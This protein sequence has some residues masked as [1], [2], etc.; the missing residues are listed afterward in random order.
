MLRDLHSYIL[1]ETPRR[2]AGNRRVARRGLDRDR[3]DDHRATGQG[4]PGGPLA[5]REP[6]PQRAEH[7]LEQRDERHLG[8]RDQARAECEEDESEPDLPDAEHERLWSAQFFYRAFSL[9]NG[10]RGRET[11]L[12][13]GVSDAG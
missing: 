12:F 9:V 11:D 3:D 7:D 4:R 6:D 10:G 8:G 5:V 1:A 13:D 2:P